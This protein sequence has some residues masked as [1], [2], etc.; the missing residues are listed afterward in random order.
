MY[1]SRILRVNCS[2]QRASL[3][4]LQLLFN[5]QARSTLGALP[6]TQFG[7]TYER[8]RAHPRASS[9]GIQAAMI[10]SEA[11]KRV[12]GLQAEE[13]AQLPHVGRTDRQSHQERARTRPGGRD[14]A[15][16]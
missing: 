1:R 2:L 3:Q 5:R 15:M 10:R 16:A 13:C 8:L 14:H 12:R 4:D 9:A 11:R 7:R 6:T